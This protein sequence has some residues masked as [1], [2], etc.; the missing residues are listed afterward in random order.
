MP[1]RAGTQGNCRVSRDLG[2]RLYSAA[3]KSYA[4]QVHAP[5][6]DSSWRIMTA[7][8]QIVS[9]LLLLGC[10]AMWIREGGKHGS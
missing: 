8:I 1:R 6:D 7:F 9:F 4:G 2:A 5:S 10:I 3:R